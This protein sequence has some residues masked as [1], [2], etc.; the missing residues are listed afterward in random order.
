V[1]AED[2]VGTLLWLTA[3][4]TT[5]IPAAGTPL[6]NRL[7][8]FKVISGPNAGQNGTSPTDPTG[9]ATF[10]YAGLG[11]LGV[12][13]I[14]ASFVDNQQRIQVSNYAAKDWANLCPNPPITINVYRG[15]DQALGSGAPFSDL[16]GTLTASGITFATDHAYIWHPFGLSSFGADITGSLDV[17]DNKTYTFT[18]DSAG[19]T[20]LF[21]DGNLLINYD[22][23]HGSLTSTGSARLT[24]G[25]HSFEI[26]IFSSF[27]VS[28]VDF[29][30]PMGISFACPPP[31]PPP[32]CTLICPQDITVS[33]DP[34]QCS[35]VVNYPAPLVSG[36]TGNVV[37]VCIPPAGAVFPAGTTTVICTATDA[38]GTTAT[39]SFD[40]TVQDTESPAITGL[41]AT[42][43]I[44][45]P[46]NNRMTP[47]RLDVAATDNCSPTTCKIISVTSS[48]PIIPMPNKRVEPYWLITG[49]LSLY[50]RAGRNTRS[51]ARTYTITVECTDAAGNASIKA[52]NVIVPE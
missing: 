52:V 31:P 10:S 30:L 51:V 6:P 1:S 42:P 41:T 22:G 48:D 40:V 33:N 4:V 47:V 9:L 28:G 36:G 3:T 27:L 15:F 49:D 44:L 19:G 20:F 18:V 34:G 29:F 37:V 24:A 50:L 16:A 2:Q 23:V 35:A 5:D 7:V 14:Q 25:I 8:T 12:D 45:R 13:V 43:P 39:C 17:S 32:S 21:I 46:I 38:S 11:G 26:Q